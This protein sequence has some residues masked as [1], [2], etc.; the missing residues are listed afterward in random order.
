MRD[1]DMKGYFWA[2]AYKFNHE[3]EW[4]LHMDSPVLFMTRAGARRKLYKCERRAFK[5]IKVDVFSSDNPLEL[6]FVNRGF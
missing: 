1:D 4:H 6:S 5:I 2:I 3:D